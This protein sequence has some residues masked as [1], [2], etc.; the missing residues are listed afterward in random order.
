[1]INSHSTKSKLY[2][3]EVEDAGITAMEIYFPSTYVDQAELEAFDNVAKGK[4]TLGLGQKE[5]AFVGEEEDVV[6]ISLTAV[7]NLMEKNGISYKDVGRLEV[8]TETQID[9]SKSIKTHLMSLFA[10]EGNF[11][12]EGVTSTNACYGS[13]NALFN[14]LNWV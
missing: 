10:Q 14:T 12:V 9:K 7:R 3:K 2:P 4:Y 8:G 6:S 5:M 13:T 11:D 1:M